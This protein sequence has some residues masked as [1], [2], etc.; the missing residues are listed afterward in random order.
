M[1]LPWTAWVSSST[2]K[3]S[4]TA[5]SIADDSHHLPAGKPRRPTFRRTLARILLLAGTVVLVVFF[6]P[7]TLGGPVSYGIVRT[8]AMT[9][10]IPKGDMVAA[11]RQP[12][13]Q[14]GDVIVY[15]GSAVRS[16]AR[17]LLLGRIVAGNGVAGFVIKGDSSPAPYR[18]TPRTPISS[19]GSGFISVGHSSLLSVASWL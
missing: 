17:E 14:N 5:A 8:S 19:E 12:T 1:V 3:R 10:T 6:R 18:V 9:P 4:T 11:I 15:R 7:Q 2:V 16:N 13:Y